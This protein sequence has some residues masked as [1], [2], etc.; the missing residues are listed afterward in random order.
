MCAAAAATCTVLASMK[1]SL[2]SS[3]TSFDCTCFAQAFDSIDST[4]SLDISHDDDSHHARLDS[5][6]DRYEDMA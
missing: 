2:Q 3:A 6:P 1:S 5:Q 4:D